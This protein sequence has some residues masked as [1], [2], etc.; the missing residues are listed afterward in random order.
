MQTKIWEPLSKMVTARRPVW[1]FIIEDGLLR[2]LTGQFVVDWGIIEEMTQNKN[3][4]LTEII[5]HNTFGI[6]ICIRYMGGE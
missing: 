6:V 3:Y 2:I 1:K 4:Q 5:S